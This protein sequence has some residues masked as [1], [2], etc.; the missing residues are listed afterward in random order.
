MRPR[1]DRW[2][3]IYLVG[4]LVSGK[5]RERPEM[6]VGGSGKSNRK[7]CCAM[8][9]G[10]GF[11]RR[12]VLESAHQITAMVESHPRS[13]TV[14]RQGLYPLSTPACAGCFRQSISAHVKPRQE[15]IVAQ[16]TTL[17]LPVSVAR[18]CAGNLTSGS[19]CAVGSAA[20]IQTRALWSSPQALSNCFAAP[21]WIGNIKPHQASFLQILHTVTLNR[22]PRLEIISES[23]K[24]YP[25]LHPHSC[26]CQ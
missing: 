12:V 6:S 19:R 11:T 16:F 23:Q 10:K 26:A 5:A 24:G 14:G 1:K 2:L 20:A 4:M 17:S 15:V 22:P 25:N 9:T 7:E 8:G 18:G 13:G 3:Q 21:H